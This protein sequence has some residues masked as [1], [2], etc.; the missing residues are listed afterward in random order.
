MQNELIEVKKELEKDIFNKLDKIKEN[1]L[2][3]KGPD[4]LFTK[5]E[6]L[7]MISDELSDVLLN[8]SDRIIEN[9]LGNDLM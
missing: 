8:W 7:T 3:G 5:I 1:M 2:T 4:D 9:N 6:M